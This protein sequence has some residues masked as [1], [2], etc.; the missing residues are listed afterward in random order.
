M[1]VGGLSNPPRFAV[2]PMLASCSSRCVRSRDTTDLTPVKRLMRSRCRTTRREESYDHEARASTAAILYTRAADRQP[3]GRTS[4]SLPEGRI[5]V[6]SRTEGGRRM[7]T[8]CLCT[9][10]IPARSL[11]R[12]P[13]MNAIP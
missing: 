10:R 3:L 12:A 7:R 13:H 5:C 6:A 4:S 9:K 11:P 1:S 8:R 2:H